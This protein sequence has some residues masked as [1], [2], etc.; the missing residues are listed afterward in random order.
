MLV[1]ITIIISQHGCT[2]VWPQVFGVNINFLKPWF[3]IMIVLFI[4]LFF[5]LSLNQV[6]APHHSITCKFP[7]K[8][9]Q[10]TQYNFGHL[11]TPSPRGVC[12]LQWP[13]MDITMA[14]FLVFLRYKKINKIKFIEIILKGLMYLKLSYST[15]QKWK[16][17]IKIMDSQLVMN[18]WI[19]PTF[20]VT[21]VKFMDMDFNFTM[22]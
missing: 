22:C 10:W 18:F 21:T 3:S 17:Q 8:F 13:Y 1:S 15:F 5:F 7:Q 4:E 14:I 12:T 20:F 11:K 16:N 9:C 2:M 19:L 6:C